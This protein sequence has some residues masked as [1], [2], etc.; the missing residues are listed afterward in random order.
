L[1][2][3]GWG[4]VGAAAGGEERG[5][6]GREGRGTTMRVSGIPPLGLHFFVC[7]RSKGGG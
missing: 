5:K 6:E 1:F 4:L 2:G 7:Q 3:R